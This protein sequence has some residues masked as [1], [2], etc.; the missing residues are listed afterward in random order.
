VLPNADYVN[1]TG[2]TAGTSSDD[3]TYANV[4]ISQYENKTSNS[5]KST[6]PEEQRAMLKTLAEYANINRLAPTSS[7]LHSSP[8]PTSATV[9][10]T[11][12][13]VGMRTFAQVTRDYMTTPR[14]E[15]TNVSQQPAQ[16]TTVEYANRTIQISS[17]APAN[18]STSDGDY[19]NRSTTT[20]QEQSSDYM[21]STL[22]PNAT[23]QQPSSDYMNLLTPA[24]NHANESNRSDGYHINKSNPAN[25]DYLNRPAA[26]WKP[27]KPSDN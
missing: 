14:V 8:A 25:G 15:S 20:S 2:D 10:S 5:S 23:T 1:R 17:A 27:A 22:A 11:P 7:V 12:A 4:G 6:L 18:S 21:T 19:M 13:A 9:T 3:A 24:G 16:L 26:S